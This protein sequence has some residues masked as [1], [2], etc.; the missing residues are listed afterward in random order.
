MTVDTM[1]DRPTM[2]SNPFHPAY[3]S[4]RLN[5]EILISRS[6]KE[7]F[8]PSAATSS[9]G[10]LPKERVVLRSR[11]LGRIRSFPDSFHS[12]NV[13]DSAIKLYCSRCCPATAANSGLLRDDAL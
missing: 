9:C 2:Y 4:D 12:K 11:F 3:R 13:A 8:V 6:V 1:L 10:A 7:S 5:L